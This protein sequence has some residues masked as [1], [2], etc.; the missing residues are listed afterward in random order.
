[1]FAMVGSSKACR[2]L[3]GFPTNFAPPSKLF[4]GVFGEKTFASHPSF[5][6]PLAMSSRFPLFDLVE[7]GPKEEAKN[8]IALNLSADMSWPLCL[9]HAWFSYVLLTSPSLQ[10]LDHK[11][12]NWY[13][14]SFEKSVLKLHQLPWF[15]V[16]IP[17]FSSMDAFVFLEVS[18]RS[19]R[20]MLL[21]PVVHKTPMCNNVLS[22]ILS[23]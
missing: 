7:P 10:K 5:E 1:M 22:L 20:W 13:Q 4:I 18:T 23:L 11:T 2:N 19:I 3:L 12:G 6:E 17:T 14:L 16:S 9:L 8:P 15:N 21:I